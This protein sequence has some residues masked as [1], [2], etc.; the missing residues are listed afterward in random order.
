[1]KISVIIVSYNTKKILRECLTSIFD[2]TKG[3]DFEV[4]IVDNASTDGSVEML[5]SR[6]KDIKIL[7]NKENLGFAKANNQ[8]IEVAT[9]DYVLLLNSDTN[10][11]ENSLKVM[12]DY[13]GSNPDVGISSCQLVGKDGEIQP[14][15]GFF[16]DLCR[17]FAWMFFL[18]DLP[19]VNKFIKPFHPHGPK[20][21][22]NDKWYN[23]FHYQD[24]VTG[25]FFLIRKEVI[26][27]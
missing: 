20:F 8:G 13:M 14:S 19:V 12:V 27:K 21:Y 7:R 24:W 1:M 26:K 18:D 17:V 15:G 25:A 6:Y 22:T 9:G 10:L 16:P 2:K 3:L 23:F 11:L 5:E 4:V